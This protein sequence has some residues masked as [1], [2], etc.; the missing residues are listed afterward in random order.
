MRITLELW[1]FLTLAAMILS[2]FFGLAW[3]LL[4]QFEKRIGERLTTISDESKGW[5]RIERELME[6]RA[7]LPTRYV[8]REDYIRNQTVIEAKLDAIS[9][10]VEI[11]QLQGAGRGH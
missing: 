9:T 6:L 11:V 2:A 10:K 1:Q 3:R 5:R 4:A 8:Q 7:E